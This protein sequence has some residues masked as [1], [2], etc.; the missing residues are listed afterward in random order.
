[1]PIPSDA[2]FLALAQARAQPSH[3]LRAVESAGDAANDIIGGYMTG[4]KLQEELAKHKTLN[5]RLGDIFPADS[6]PGGLTPDHTVGQ[7]MQLAPILPYTRS[8]VADMIG[9]E[10]AGNPQPSVPAQPPQPPTPPSAPGDPN[11]I[12][13]TSGIDAL[14]DNQ[15]VP[16]PIPGSANP[17]QSPGMTALQT[18][19]GAGQGDQSNFPPG[20]PT[21]IAGGGGTPFKGMSYMDLQRYGPF[22]NDIRQGRQFQQ[23]QANENERARLSREQAERNFQIAQANEKGRAIAGA[24]EKVAPGASATAQLEA[25]EQ[26][27]TTINSD[28]ANKSIP[29]SGNLGSWYANKWALN[30]ASADSI[31]NVGAGAIEKLVEG[32]Y[33]EQQKEAIQKALFPTGN[34]LGTPR[35]DQ[36]LAQLHAY[37]AQAKAGNVGQVKAAIDAIA[38]G[39]ATNP[40]TMVTPVASVLPSGQG[41][42][43]PTVGSDLGGGVKV[44]RVLRRIK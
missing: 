36:K 11:E 5:T 33:N 26:G 9:N 3:A 35:A 40:Q 32:R 25:L 29:F 13:D 42:S 28:P 17:P 30:Q 23:G 2:L 6:I 18:A 16:P 44:R 34:E 7:L 14:R 12:T 31:A 20:T 27:I 41:S 21:T 15:P 24:E 39:T 4:T 19:G 22:I 38:S 1:M 10:L 8:P 43:G 37:I